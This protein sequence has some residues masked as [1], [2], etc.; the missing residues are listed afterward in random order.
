MAEKY[1]PALMLPEV[2]ALRSPASLMLPVGWFKPKRA[3]DVYLDRPQTMLLTGVL[4][5]G[6]DYERVSFTPV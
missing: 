1:I 4:E 6:S 3:I 2:A 5:R